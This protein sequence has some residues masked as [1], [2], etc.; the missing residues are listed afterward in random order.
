MTH[1]LYLCLLRSHK[2]VLALTAASYFV[3]AD[4][5]VSGP[6]LLLGATQTLGLVFFYTSLFVAFIRN[7]FFQ[8]HSRC[9]STKAS[10]RSHLL[11]CALLHLFFRSK[12]HLRDSATTHEGSVAVPP[13]ALPQLFIRSS[14]VLHSICLP[15]VL[16]LSL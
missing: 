14:V 5:I 1:V 6:G 3:P 9:S 16:S 12:P 8:M 4:A 11:V 10:P 2:T 15:C 7:F 13:L